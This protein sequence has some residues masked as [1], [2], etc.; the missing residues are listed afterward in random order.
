[1][2]FDGEP[3]MCGEPEKNRACVSIRVGTLRK[4][5]FAHIFM[6]I[7]QKKIKMAVKHKKCIFSPFLSL[8]WTA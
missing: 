5:T 1:M 3:N 8:H 6:G 2:I 4:A 7:K